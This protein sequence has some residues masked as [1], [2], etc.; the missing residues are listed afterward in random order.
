MNKIF[1]IFSCLIVLLV[2]A[3]SQEEE[4][5]TF[6][7]L[8][9]EE[10]PQMFYVE[11]VPCQEGVYYTVDNFNNTVLPEWQ[12]LIVEVNSP[13]NSA[14]GLSRFNRLAEDEEDGFWQLIWNSKADSKAAWEAWSSN[15]NV[16][17]WAE[18][19]ADVLTC[20]EEKRYS[21]DAY[22]A[23]PNNT[24]G[25]FELENFISEYFQCLY[26][27]DKKPE[28]LRAVVNELEA[29]LNEAQTLPGPFT[30]V[31]LGP[32][33]ESEEVDFFWG[34]FY[35]SED[36][37]KT[38]DDEWQKLSPKVEDNWNLVSSCQEPRYYNSGDIPKS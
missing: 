5:M 34:N 18:R 21:F 9:S 14:Y 13:L 31:I 33:Y 22:I 2:T 35:Q 1:I 4:P 12:D 20:D 28:D 24:F 27:E 7:S 11:Y 38:F 16:Q 29:F 6:A 23:R 10:Y 30:Y 19:H 8:G 25:E 26:R 36:Q 17:E 37:R 32:D 15:Q 3:C